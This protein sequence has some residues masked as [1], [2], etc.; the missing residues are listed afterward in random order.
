[1]GRFH[2]A[3]GRGHSHD[4]IDHDHD[5]ADHHDHGVGDRSGYQTGGSLAQRV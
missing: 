4:D 1:M 3:D 5:H 2:H